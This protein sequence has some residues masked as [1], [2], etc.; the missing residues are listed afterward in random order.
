[1]SNH[2]LLFILLFLQIN[3]QFV[4]TIQSK[5]VRFAKENE[6]SEDWS[7]GIANFYLKFFSNG[8][9]RLAENGKTFFCD[10]EPKC[11]L[12]VYEMLYKAGLELPLINQM[13]QNCKKFHED[14]PEGRPPTNKDLVDGN[15]FPLLYLVG[16]DQDG[17]NNAINGDIISNGSHMGIIIEN[18][19]TISASS[20]SIRKSDFNSYSSKTIYIFRYDKGIPIFTYSIKTKNNGIQSEVISRD[21]GSAGI[22]GDPIIGIAIK[23]D[24]CKVNYRVHVNGGKWLPMIENKYD[25]N[26]I[27]GYAGND[28]EIDLIEVN[29]IHC[30]YNPRITMWDVPY[31]VAPLNNQNYYDWQYGNKKGKGLDG[32]AGAKG[33]SIDLFQIGYD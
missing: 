10:Y 4:E 1:M 32:Y 12:F 24:R 22:K 25:W 9:D 15:V 14:Q 21:W 19:E 31:R 33:K 23:V 30:E 26:D 2:I 28:K 18:K 16:T 7:Y 29:F 13:S 5:V 27:N 11:N 20:N 8:K 6:G 17:I 3:S